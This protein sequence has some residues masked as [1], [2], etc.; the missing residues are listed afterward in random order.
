MAS[1]QITQCSIGEFLSE[2]CYN[3]T[4]SISEFSIHDQQL[5]LWRSGISYDDSM[6]EDVT[7]CLHHSEKQLRR[8]SLNEKKCC[9]PFNSH[10]TI[11]K[12][13]LKIITLQQ[14]KDVKRSLL[15]I[16]G[17]KLCITCQKKVSKIQENTESNSSE[18]IEEDVIEQPCTSLEVEP[19]PS[20]SFHIEKEDVDTSL[21]KLGVSPV[22]LHAVPQHSRTILGKRK[23][24]TATAALQ[25]KLAHVYVGK[26]KFET[27]SDSSSEDD[28]KQIKQN[29]EDFKNLISQIKQ[30]I[31]EVSNR[32][33]NSDVDIN[34]FVMV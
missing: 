28:K 11:V 7:V 29:A 30:K 1:S 12:R 23:L 32:E 22:K 19:I 17:K 2:N 16:L 14:A 21:T 9:D 4:V 34:T 15:L 31:G 26:E 10:K 3:E 5:L 20:T 25:S 13:K 18:K 8:F 33:K 24:H 6:P 27:S